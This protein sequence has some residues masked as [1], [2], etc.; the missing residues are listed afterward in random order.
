M[1]PLMVSGMFP[2]VRAG[3]ITEALG[4]PHDALC[5]MY[6]PQFDFAYDRIHAL[7]C[8]TQSDFAEF[9][10]NNKYDLIHV[11]NEPNWPV[12]VAKESQSAPVLMNV[13]DV[14]CARPNAA[15]NHDPYEAAAF[16]AADAFVFVSEWQRDFCIAQGFDVKDKPYCVL[17]NYASD[18][19]IVQKPLLPHVGGVVYAGG[20]DAR[21]KQGSWRDLSPVADEMQKRGVEFH[22]YPGNPGI[23]YGTVHDT[24]MEYHLLTHRL[25][26][27]DWGF[28]GTM[29]PNDAWHHSYPNKVFEYFAAGIPVIALNNPLIKPLCDEGLGVYLDDV[30]DLRQ[31][32]RLDHKRYVKHVKANRHRFTMGYNIQPLKDLY[33]QLRGN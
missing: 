31:L 20:L 11:H 28:S 2:C 5:R 18:S 30:G 19:T 23:D 14:T 22:V 26:Q 16:Q 25:S 21:D 15:D 10:R 8:G 24:V 1:K 6:P 17:P 32:P 7:R 13:H 12:V 9:F 33:A 29:H 3:K 27:H 4:T